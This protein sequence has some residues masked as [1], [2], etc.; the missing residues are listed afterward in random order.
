MAIKV[1]LHGTGDSRIITV[2]QH[3][4]PTASRERSWAKIATAI[5]S[6]VTTPEPPAPV[7]P[8]TDLSALLAEVD[9]CLDKNP[10][11]KRRETVAD[12]ERRRGLK[13]I[14]DRIKSE[15]KLYA[16]KSETAIALAKKLGVIS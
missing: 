3:I 10:E 6:E 14:D 12:I 5:A 7:K 4:I 8:T 16:E 2:N 13:K 1:S 9:A 11:A 15:R